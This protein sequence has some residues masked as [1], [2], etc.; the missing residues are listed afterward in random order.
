MAYVTEDD[1]R[2]RLRALVT[3]DRSQVDIAREVGVSPS[4]I[5]SVL[6]GRK[7]PT[8]AILKLVGLAPVHLYQEVV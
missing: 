4:F 3:I 2:K 6:H 5:G 1:A 7:R 8:K